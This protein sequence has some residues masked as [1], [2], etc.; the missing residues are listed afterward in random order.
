MR[1]LI[2]AIGRARVG[3][4][5]ELFEH[6]TR[7][8]R[9]PVELKELEERRKPPPDQLRAREGALLLAATPP[10]AAVVALDER[11]TALSSRALAARIGQ[12]RDD[13]RGCI[14]FLIGGAEGLDKAVRARADLVLSFGKLTWP[15]M[16]ARGML[17]EQ[18]YRSQQILAGHPYHRD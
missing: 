8:L 2:C 16:L 6:Y 18:I 13:G 12:W 3:P 14:A 1:I 10:D 17:A 5:R 7:L 15:H 11:G 9:W 4:A